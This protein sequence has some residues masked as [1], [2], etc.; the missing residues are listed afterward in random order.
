MPIRRIPL[1]VGEFY[2]VFNRGISHQPTFLIKSDY[3][4]AK[5]ALSYYQYNS[6][7]MRLSRFKE[8]SFEQRTEILNQFEVLKE[9]SVRIVSFVLMPNHFHFLLYQTAENGVSKF[10]NNFTNSYTRY[11]NTKHEKVGPIFQGRFKAVHIET[12]EQ[13]MHVSRYIHL[14]PVVS[15]VIKD[16]ELLTYPWSSFPDYLKGTSSNIWLE[17]ILKQFSSS[18]AYRKFVLDHIDYAKKLEGIKH[19]VLE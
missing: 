15:Y 13:L 12:T 1:A 9:F 19:L 17:P 18:D 2:H 14:N 6:L 5:L 3:E 11:F 7:P 16:K 10:L 4:Q 8:Q